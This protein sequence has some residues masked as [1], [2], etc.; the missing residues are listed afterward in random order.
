VALGCVVLGQIIYL[1]LY[2]PLTAETTEMFRFLPASVASFTLPA[3]AYGIATCF[4]RRRRGS[5]SRTQPTDVTAD[6]QAFADHRNIVNP[7]I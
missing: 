1:M 5:S 2:N 7:N 6:T 3:V 4:L